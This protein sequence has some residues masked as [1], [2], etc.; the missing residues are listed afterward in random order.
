NG[1]HVGDVARSCTLVSRV[2]DPQA[3]RQVSGLALPAPC[4]VQLGETAGF[5]PA[6]QAAATFDR[7][8][9]RA[10]IRPRR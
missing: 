8:R 7:S 1:G 4:R 9:D 10:R 3:L 6:P 2:W 5:K